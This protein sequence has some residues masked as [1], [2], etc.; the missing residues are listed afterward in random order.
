MPQIEPPINRAAAHLASLLF[1][2]TQCTNFHSYIP[3]Q[4]SGHLMTF[5]LCS[6]L[7]RRQRA[8]VSRLRAAVLLLAI[9][10]QPLVGLGLYEFTLIR[11]IFFI[12]LQAIKCYCNMF[13]YFASALLLRM[14]GVAPCIFPLPWC[15]HLLLSALAVP[16]L[17]CCA[18]DIFIVDL[19]L[20]VQPGFRG[21]WH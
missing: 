16:S 19:V 4:F 18:L 8:I 3:L 12:N 14:F 11:V 13:N 10:S 20:F 9:T 21:R 2:A 15:I 6:L 7:L 17:F 1:P 5:K